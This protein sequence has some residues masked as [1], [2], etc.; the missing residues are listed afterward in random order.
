[1]VDFIQHKLA[2]C[3]QRRDA[4]AVGNSETLR[5]AGPRWEHVGNDD[6]KCG[7]GRVWSQYTVVVPL[8]FWNAKRKKRT[9]R[10]RTFAGSVILAASPTW[11]CNRF[12]GLWKGL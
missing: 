4:W 8:A 10:V 11:G 3:T 1:M 6:V 5:G 7:L 12:D 2:K 9:Y